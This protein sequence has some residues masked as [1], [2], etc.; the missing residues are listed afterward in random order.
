MSVKGSAL[1]YVGAKRG[2]IDHL[3]VATTKRHGNTSQTV[4]QTGAPHLR[5]RST[6]PPPAA[7]YQKWLDGYPIQKHGRARSITGEKLR[8]IVRMR[9]NG[10]SLSEAARAVGLSRSVAHVW[11]FSLPPELAV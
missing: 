7:D 11:V 2:K 1:L 4:I 3:E 6:E 5:C 8:R 9:R 10:Y